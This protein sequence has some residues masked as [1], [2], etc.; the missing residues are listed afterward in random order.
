VS[1]EEVRRTAEPYVELFDASP[2]GAAI[3]R[4]DAPR[5]EG[6]RDRCDEKR[7]RKREAMRT[8]GLRHVRRDRG[9]VL[10]E[11]RRAGATLVS[12]DGGSAGRRR[13]QRPEEQQGA[14][15]TRDEEARRRADCHRSWSEMRALHAYGNSTDPRSSANRFNMAIA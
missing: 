7:A 9:L 10:D 12:R 11:V 13:V 14:D 6:C 8:R 4:S 1:D 3:A 5:G 15:R 2:H